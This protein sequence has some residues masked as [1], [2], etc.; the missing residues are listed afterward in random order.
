MRTKRQIL[1]GLAASPNIRVRVA[2]LRRLCAREIVANKKRPHGLNPNVK[3]AFAVALRGPSRTWRE[4]FVRLGRKST[5]GGKGWMPAR[6]E[7]VT[8]REYFRGKH[9]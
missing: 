6:G 1:R 5:S 3:T 8:E 2:A 9:G 4:R 7:R